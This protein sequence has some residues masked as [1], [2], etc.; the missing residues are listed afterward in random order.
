MNLKP[1]HLYSLLVAA[2]LQVLGWFL[3]FQV[4]SRTKLWNCSGTSKLNKICWEYGNRPFGIAVI[5]ISLVFAAL[6]IR[7]AKKQQPPS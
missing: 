3:V 7:E 5:L 2:L 6:V 1:A 4:T